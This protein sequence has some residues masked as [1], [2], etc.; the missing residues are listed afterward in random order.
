MVTI[1]NPA[2]ACDIAKAFARLHSNESRAS[3]SCDC[4][5]FDE[6]VSSIIV[7]GPSLVCVTHCF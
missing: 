7:V 6:I 1:V 2:E 3:R 4:V 5:G